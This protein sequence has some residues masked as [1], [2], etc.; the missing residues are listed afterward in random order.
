M[1]AYSDMAWM[2][3]S[4][5]VGRSYSNDYNVWMNETK[6][7]YSKLLDNLNRYVK[8]LQLAAKKVN[9]RVKVPSIAP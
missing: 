4:R 6:N 2:I 5:S 3:A 7:T 1:Q 8:T 9:A